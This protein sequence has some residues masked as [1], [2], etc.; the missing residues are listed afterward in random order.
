MQ[1]KQFA[2]MLVRYF[3]FDIAL[4]NKMCERITAENYQDAVSKL[5]DLRSRLNNN[6]TIN[7]RA[8]YT[9]RALDNLFKGN[10]EK[11]LENK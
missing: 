11:M 8:A 4:A 1:K 10:T 2:N 3:G 7:D 9:Y 5:V 6:L